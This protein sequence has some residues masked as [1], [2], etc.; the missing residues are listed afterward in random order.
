MAEIL[1]VLLVLGSELVD[2][3]QDIPDSFEEIERLIW[4]YLL[5]KLVTDYVEMVRSQVLEILRVGDD[6]LLEE[7]TRDLRKSFFVGRDYF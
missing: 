2:S 7:K 4:V 3:T 1:E 6:F 5:L